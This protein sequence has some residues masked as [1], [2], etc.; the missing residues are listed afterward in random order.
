MLEDLTDGD[1]LRLTS[2][3]E[4]S[5]DMQLGL[6]DRLA[7]G[8]ESLVH[9]SLLKLLSNSEL[10]DGVLNGNHGGRKTYRPQRREFESILKS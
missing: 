4:Q 10:V 6:L 9:H 7:V 5:K 8:G 1:L 3:G 2:T